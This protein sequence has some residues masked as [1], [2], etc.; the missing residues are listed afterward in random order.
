M[1][2]AEIVSNGGN[3]QRC[4]IIFKPEE[5]HLKAKR[6]STIDIDE[7]KQYIRLKI[8]NDTDHTTVMNGDKM[9]T[10]DKEHQKGR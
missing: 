4:N 6:I 3:K 5:L 10:N 1:N 2:Q 8:W 9:H 7:I